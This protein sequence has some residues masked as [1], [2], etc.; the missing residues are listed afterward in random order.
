MVAPNNA[1][2]DAAAADSN[3]E[4]KIKA[5]SVEETIINLQIVSILLLVISRTT[6]SIDSQRLNWCL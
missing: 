3:Q 5:E 6:I 4:T 2:N 1:N